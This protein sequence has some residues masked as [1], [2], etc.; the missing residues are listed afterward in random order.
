MRP[1]ETEIRRLVRQWLEKADLDYKAVLRI[2]PDPELREIA[3]FH[4]Q[5]AVE[6]YLKAV[7]TRHQVEFPKTHVLRRLL[8]LLGGVEPAMAKELDAVNWLTPFGAD[9]DIQ[10]T[11]PKRCQGTRCARGSLPRMP[12]TLSW[13]LSI[14]SWKRINPLQAV[15]RCE[16]TYTIF[17]PPEAWM[18]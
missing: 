10:G 13:R 4:A 7:L 11:A 14:P 6:K 16:Q 3:A 8:I 12:E 17:N 15:S 9:S 5:Q 1:P 2:E 18:F